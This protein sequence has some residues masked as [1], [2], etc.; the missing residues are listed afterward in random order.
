MPR[1]PAFRTD[2]RTAAVRAA[3][4]AGCLAF[5]VS[6][7]QSP[8]WQL[9]ASFT[10]L[11]MKKD[12]P[13]MNGD[14]DEVPVRIA[15][16]WTHAVRNTAGEISERGFG[17]RVSFYG[18]KDDKSIATDGRLVV[19]AFDEEGRSPTD[20]RPTRRYVFPPE[21]FDKHR[22][23]SEAGP[24]YSFWLPW[25]AVG[26]PT[27]HISLIVR[28]E[29][30]GGPLVMSEQ[31]RHVLPGQN[32]VAAE[33][34]APQDSRERSV[35]LAEHRDSTATKN[36]TADFQQQPTKPPSAAHVTPQ[37]GLKTTSIALPSRFKRRWPQGAQ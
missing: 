32:P 30:Q 18:K 24:Y 16:S 10:N 23:D 13:W 20:H 19:Y 8:S 31:T 25:D 26:G 35:Q 21:T 5:L 15:G 9:P 7:C 29:P 36:T 3:T 28:F 12:I 6:G 11:D 17:G 34:A 27:K 33:D 4:I 22:T 37:S 2:Q 14:E 1:S